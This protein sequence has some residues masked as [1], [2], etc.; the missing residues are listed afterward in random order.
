MANEVSNLAL[1]PT[2]QL[3][4]KPNYLAGT[5]PEVNLRAETFWIAQYKSSGAL[6]SAL[7]A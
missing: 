6:F 5:T 7:S 1:I 4:I 3:R 2:N